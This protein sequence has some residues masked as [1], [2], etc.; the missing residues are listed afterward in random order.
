MFIAL[1]KTY[2]NYDKYEKKSNL[3]QSNSHLSM[4]NTFSQKQNKF[5][6]YWVMV[7]F[8]ELINF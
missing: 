2:I 8:K 6:T 3:S 1:C 7:H 4:T 5:N